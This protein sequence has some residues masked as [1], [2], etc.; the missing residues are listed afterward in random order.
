[1]SVDGSVTA[2]EFYLAADVE[3]DIYINSIS[4]RIADGGAPNLN[5]FGNLTALTNGVQWLWVTNDLGTVELHDGIQTNLEFIR[6]GQK[7]H[8]I[9]T[10][11][12][13]YLADV[14][15]GGTSKAYLPIIDLSEQF[16]KPW[17]IRLRKGTED[18]MKFV[19]R[20]DLSTLDAFDAIAYGIMF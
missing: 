11:T 17:G 13:A 19:V 2:Q 16:G 15:G 18:K 12:E 9:G 1:M 6:T 3:R 20:D 5:K 8:A 7:T 14:S 4:V 10:G